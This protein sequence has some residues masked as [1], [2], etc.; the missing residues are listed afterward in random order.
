MEGQLLHIPEAVSTAAN[1]IACE[2][3]TYTEVVTTYGLTCLMLDVYRPLVP[4]HLITRLER[5]RRKMEKRYPD[6]RVILYWQK[7]MDQPQ[8]THTT[9]TPF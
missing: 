8:Q 5:L 3:R 2:H 9:P 7:V 1:A 4:P 6:L